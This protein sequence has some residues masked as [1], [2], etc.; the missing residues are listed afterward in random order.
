MHVIVI[1]TK[2]LLVSHC[3]ASRL[4]DNFEE[5][6]S[7]HQRSRFPPYAWTWGP[8]PTT[9]AVRR[10]RPI[11]RPDHV[12]SKSKVGNRIVIVSSRDFRD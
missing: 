3:Q 8:D 5:N 12:L 1:I 4:A 11:S 10:V 2:S 6:V 9:S 7:E